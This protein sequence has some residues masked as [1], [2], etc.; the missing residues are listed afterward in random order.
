MRTKRNS[1][2]N[3][4]LNTKKNQKNI[5]LFYNY[6][7][8]PPFEPDYKIKNY[9]R[10]IL[11]CKVCGHFTASHKIKVHE[12]YKKNYSIISHGDDMRKK[13]DKLLS[14]KS[15]SDNHY[16]IKRILSK[17]K[18]LKAKEIRLLDV[19][20]GLG[21]FLYQLKK[22][23][24]WNLIGI[25]PDINFVKFSKKINIKVL[26]S[27][28]KSNTFKKNSFNIITMNKIIEHVKNPVK[29]LKISKKLLN[30]NGHA[31]IEVPDGHAASKHKD[32]KFRQEFNVDHLHV[33]TKKS[34][35]D[36]IG[37]AG[38]KLITCNNIKEKSGKLTLF[39]FAKKIT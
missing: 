34:L 3:C 21:I 28:L 12:F 31:Y 37:L 15:K 4:F 5:E 10:K 13:F 24:N 8:R 36:C 18:N 38:L 25:E 27:N 22:K 9:K 1:K 39:A 35:K 26:H 11:R 29:L 14:L 16:R 23:V 30:E 33:F 2:C 6:N 32:K 7:S 20:S 17:F 19:G